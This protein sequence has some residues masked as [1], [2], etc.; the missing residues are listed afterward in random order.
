MNRLTAGAVVN[1]ENV[2]WYGFE[3]I[4]T[5]DTFFPLKKI[6]VNTIN[7]H[8]DGSGEWIEMTATSTTVVF[9][10]VISHRP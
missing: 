7:L 8:S 5:L 1:P 2:F 4:S 6:F 9:C 3:P 10:L